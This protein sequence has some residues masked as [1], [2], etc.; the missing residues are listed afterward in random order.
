VLIYY[1]SQQSQEND[2]G[3]LK[4]IWYKI[5]NQMFPHKEF[6]LFYA[7]VLFQPPTPKSVFPEGLKITTDLEILNKI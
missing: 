2:L 3:N 1:R 4:M 5:I 6:C 7:L